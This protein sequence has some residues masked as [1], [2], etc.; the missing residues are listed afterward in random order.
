MTTQAEKQPASLMDVLTLLHLFNSVS[1]GVGVAIGYVITA[2]HHGQPVNVA[3]MLGAALSTLLISSGGFI[4]NDI[5]DVD[6]DRVNRPDRPLAAGKVSLDTARALYVIISGIGLAL[7][8]AINAGTGLLAVITT[9]A[10]FAYSYRFTRRL[11]IGHL[12]IAALG[13]L[14]FPFGGIAAGHILPT[15]Y[16]VLFTFSA[17]FAREVLK[18]VPD[19]AGDKA[20]GVDNV[21]T[22]YGAKAALR[23]GQIA[24]LLTAVA[25]PVVRL[26]WPLNNLFLAIAFLIVWPVTFYTLARATVE[27]TSGAI[28]VS[29]LIFLLVAVALLVGSIQF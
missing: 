13:A 9:L 5:L 18:T 11:L 21:A 14:L 20:N 25:L 26:V 23:L 12:T 17:F 4:I 24:L 10:L 19:Y 15:L 1:S 2:W 6:I 16:S 7:A 27:N 29:K 8:W 28:R 3:A 22:R